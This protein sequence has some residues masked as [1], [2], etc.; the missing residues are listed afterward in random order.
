MNSETCLATDVQ[1][2]PDLMRAESEDAAVAALGAILL[3]HETG[4]LTKALQETRAEA[5][6]TLKALAQAKS[7]AEAEATAAGE[8]ARK[9]RA[10]VAALPDL[11]EALEAGRLAEARVERASAE[12]ELAQLE[13]TRQAARANLEQ[14]ARPRVRSATQRLSDID[15]RL[16]ALAEPPAP[17]PAIL[18]ALAEA[19]IGGHRDPD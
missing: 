9:A 17:D 16:I 8:A 4:V 13:L 1:R 15:A 12:A 5:V 2:L 18:A 10:V 3:R 14:M 6:A 11:A 7:E 19:M